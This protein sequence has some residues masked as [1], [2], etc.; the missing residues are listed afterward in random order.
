MR[1]L[2]EEIAGKE[3]DHPAHP[4]VVVTQVE[5]ESVGVREK[6]H[7]TARGGRTDLWLCEHIELQVADIGRQVLRVLE[8]AVDSCHMPANP[9]L[10]FQ[11]LRGQVRRLYNVAKAY[12]YVLVAADS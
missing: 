9:R 10:V 2:S 11:T 7:G 1:T 12:L 5:N 8:S 3:F 4:T 6:S